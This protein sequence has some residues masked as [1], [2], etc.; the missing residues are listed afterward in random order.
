MGEYMTIQV[1]IDT[2]KGEDMYATLLKAKKKVKADKAAELKTINQVANLAT[3]YVAS[4]VAMANNAVGS[5][6]GNQLRQ[7]NINATLGIAT[8]VAAIGI[9]IATQNYVGAALTAGA[10][11]VSTAKQAI[12]Y[13][14]RVMN[15]QE[16]SRYRLAYLGNPT[17]SGSRFKGERR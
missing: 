14:I 2:E 4:A 6:T 12:N 5:Y 3:G 17:T 1:H 13:N 16:E 11:I 10:A 7:S 8:T 9:Q 15:S